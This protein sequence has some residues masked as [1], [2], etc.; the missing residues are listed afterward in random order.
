MW[1]GTGRRSRLGVLR[2]V[3]AVHPSLRQGSACGVPIER[4][5]RALAA[6]DLDLALAPVEQNLFNECKSN[7]RLLEY[8]ACGFP[9]GLQRRA[10]LPGRS[11]GDA[12]EEPFPRLG[13]RD[14][15]AYP[16]PGCRGQGR[17]HLRERVLADWMLD[18]ERLRA[19]YRAWMPD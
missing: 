10:L 15:H 7:L 9:G 11:A 18:G 19:W 1:S 6:L 5:P 14:P 2:H 8:G 16:R 4:Y 17:D 13:G 12:G 3:P